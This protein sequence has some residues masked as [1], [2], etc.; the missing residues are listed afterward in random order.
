MG[1]G[2]LSGELK[3]KDGSFKPGIDPPL[4]IRMCRDSLL[5]MAMA[6]LLPASFPAVKALLVLV[7]AN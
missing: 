7:C 6:V 2:G 5:D 1:K 4:S 3:T